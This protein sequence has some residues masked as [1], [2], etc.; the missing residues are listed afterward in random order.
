MLTQGSAYHIAG[1]NTTT[2][3]NLRTFF[4]ICIKLV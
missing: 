4:A 2:D 1:I 3:K